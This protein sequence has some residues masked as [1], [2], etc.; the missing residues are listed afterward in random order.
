MAIAAAGTVGET[1]NPISS[2]GMNTKAAVTKRPHITAVRSANCSVFLTRIFRSQT[3]VETYYRLCRLSDCVPNHEDKGNIIACYSESANAII[4]K[5]LH[6]HLIT[7]E[8][9]N[10]KGGLR[11]QCGKPDLTLIH[12]I[13]YGESHAHNR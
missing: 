2:R 13:A 9:Q 8:H 1:N 4:S 5:V 11:K 10:C 12:K 7:R 3:E 6:K